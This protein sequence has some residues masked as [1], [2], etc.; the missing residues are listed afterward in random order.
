LILTDTHAHL[1][2]SN[3]DS[4]LDESLTRAR[5]AG[6]Q[7]LVNVGTNLECSRGA[8]AFA[9]RHADCYA[10]VGCH[11]H[12][13]KEFHDEQMD[14]FR[15]LITHP[16]VKAIGE[17]GLDYF[18]DHSPHD[19]QRT[20]F[21]KFLHLHK[22]T[23][24]PL[25]FHIRDAHADVFEILHEEF[26]A[27]VNAL[28]HCFSGDREVAQHAI[29]MGMYLSFACNTTY[30]KNLF[31]SDA[32]KIVPKERIVLETD[33]PYLPPEG[34]RGKRNEPSYIVEGLRFAARAMDVTTEEL[35]RLTTE[36]AARFFGYALNPNITAQ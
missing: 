5:E 10:A 1:H 20:V 7:Y 27:H 35:A 18:R 28:M 14:H 15:T 19:V 8:V 29:D 25:V 36:N 23:G 32:L 24:L 30:K 16:K 33:S 26:G 4:D 21:R 17:V 22:E 2:F 3:F 9:E 34:L 13:S 12:D 31:L 11:P 6:V